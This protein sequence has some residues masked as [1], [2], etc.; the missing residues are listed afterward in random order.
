MG[1]EIGR[2]IHDKL[3]TDFTSLKFSNNQ[4]IFNNVKK[5]YASTSM[6]ALDCLIIPDSLSENVQGGSAGNTQT[7]RIYR[8]RALS[9]E[10]IEA[11]DTDNVGNIKYSRLLNIADSILDYLQKEPSNLNSWGSTNSINIYKI[12]VDSPRYDTQQTENGYNAFIDISFSVYLSL[13]PQNL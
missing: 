2:A 13:I 5:F 10:Q 9:Y 11:A 4:N 3:I 8:F 6:E 1:Q 12:R 7:T